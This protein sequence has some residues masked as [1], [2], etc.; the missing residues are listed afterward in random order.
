[1]PQAKTDQMIKAVHVV[2][3]GSGEQHREHRYGRRLPM[4]WWIFM[5]RSWIKL[6]INAFVIEH[7][8]GLILFDTGLDPAIKSDPNYISQ[9]IGRFLLPKIFKLHIGSKDSVG[10]QQLEVATQSELRPDYDLAQN[11]ALTCTLQR[12]RNR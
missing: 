6:P 10:N 11:F 12:L 8:D 2:S 9:A 1:M 4:L 7:R 3:T 5:S